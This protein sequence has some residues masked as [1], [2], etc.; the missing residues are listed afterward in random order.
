MAIVLFPTLLSMAPN[1]PVSLRRSQPAVAGQEMCRFLWLSAGLLKC[2]VPCG[3]CVVGMSLSFGLWL[4]SLQ[5][6]RPPPSCIQSWLCSPATK[7]P[8]SR[9]ITHLGLRLEELEVHLK[10]MDRSPQTSF[11]ITDHI[12]LIVFVSGMFW[13]SPSQHLWLRAAFVQ[14]MGKP[15]CDRHLGYPLMVL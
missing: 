6:F 15:C 2:K 1:A 14:R 4:W 8:V 7:P 3:L 12:K 11:G 13:G 9:H 5:H 10:E